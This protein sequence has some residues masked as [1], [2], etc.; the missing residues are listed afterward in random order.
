MNIYECLRTRRTVREFKPDP[1]SDES[2]A[3]LLSAAR[4]SPSSRNQQPWRFIVIRERDTLASLGEAASSGGFLARAPLAIAIVME[5]ADQPEMEAGRA[6]QQMELVAWSEGMG[7][8]F[9]TLSDDQ[10]ESIADLLCIPGDLELITVL[11][12]GYRREDFQGQGIPR[13]PLSQLV[14]VERFGNPFPEDEAI[15]ADRSS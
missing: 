12:F 13:K 15:A 5:N 1:V 3:K 6:L 7:T 4:W 14:H 2:L 10:R 8:C 9:V 11:P